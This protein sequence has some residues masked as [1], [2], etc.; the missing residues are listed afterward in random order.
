MK[1]TLYHDLQTQQFFESFQGQNVDK[2]LLSSELFLIDSQSQKFVRFFAFLFE[3]KI[4][5]KFP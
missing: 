3:G 1:K 2:F 4:F 5:F